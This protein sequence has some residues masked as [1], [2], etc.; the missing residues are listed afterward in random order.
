MNRTK[1]IFVA[2]GVLGALALFLAI[3]RPAALSPAA[4]PPADPHASVAL[5]ARLSQGKLLRGGPGEVFLDIGLRGAPAKLSSRPPLNVALVIDRS[6][7]M[8]GTKLEHARAAAV[9]FVRH[10]RDGD[11]LAVVTYGSDVTVLV[12]SVRI[13]PETRRAALD[14]IQGITDRGGTYLSGGLEAG[15]QEVFKHI[16]SEQVSRVLVISDGQANEGV[17]TSRGLAELARRTADRGASVTT[18]GVGLDFNEDVMTAL[19]E[20]GSGHYYFINDAGQM[21]GIFSKE[22]EA[23]QA[24][25]GQRP[26]LTLSLAPGVELV[27]VLG[28]EHRR[29]GHRAIIDL[30]AVFGGQRRKV[31]CRLRVPAGRAGS[32]PVSRVELSYVDTRTGSQATVASAVDVAV[33]A[34]PEAARRSENAKVMERV[35]EARIAAQVTGAMDRFAEGDVAAARA[36]LRSEVIRARAASRRLRSPKLGKMVDALSQDLE[37]TKAPPASSAGRTLVKQRKAD[38]YNAYK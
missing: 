8:A 25:V 15:R 4:A 17:T 18:I 30:P 26:R 24:T 7:S 22:L 19:A 29:E 5:H 23:L 13:A 1:A 20:A 12:P 38:A 32:V 35:E 14:A 9:T 16:V 6:G 27:E 2:A 36:A 33:V 28:Y 21:A 10:L 31:I 3:G 34:D 11:R 37:A